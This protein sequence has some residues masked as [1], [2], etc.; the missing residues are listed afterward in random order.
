MMITVTMIV[1]NSSMFRDCHV[2]SPWDRRL[3][4]CGSFV[5]SSDF[6]EK[7]QD[8]QDPVKR[9]TTSWMLRFFL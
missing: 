3:K 4:I 2:E 7:N 6:Q 5:I 1:L 9:I 8:Q